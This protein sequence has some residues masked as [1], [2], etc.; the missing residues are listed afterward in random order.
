MS[1][2]YAQCGQE[3]EAVRCLRLAQ[4]VFPEIPENDPSFLFA[5]GGQFTLT[6]WEGLTRLD[7]DQPREAWNALAQIER[8]PSTIIVPERMR[9]EITNHRAEA[10]V[11]L[12]NLELFCDYIEAGVIGAKNL[13]SER[14]YN[15]AFGVYKL[16]KRLWRNEPR[17]KELQDL[18]VRQ[19]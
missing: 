15:E 6:L 13:G 11:A 17:V 10:A 16:A 14:R 2:A 19:G 1:N 12:G 3:Q 8:L 18:F 9:L 5:D 4:A 7:L